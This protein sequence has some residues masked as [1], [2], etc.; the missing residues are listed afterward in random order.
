[1]T[2]RWIAERLQMGT[3][4]HVN[5][6]LYWNRKRGEKTFLMKICQYQ[7]LVGSV[8]LGPGRGQF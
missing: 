1:M 6:L 5:H 2:A 8:W 4:G 3:M 7:E